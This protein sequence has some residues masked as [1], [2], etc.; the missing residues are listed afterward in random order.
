L[1]GL[2]RVI[3]SE[4]PDLGARIIDIAPALAP[5]EAAELAVDELLFGDDEDEVIL[6]GSQRRVPR[7]TPA[8]APAGTAARCKL[9]I[10]QPGRLDNLIW[11]ELPGFEPDDDEVE[12]R[13]MATGLNFRDIMFS[14]GLLPE[15]AL[16]NGFAGASLGLEMAGVVTKTGKKA[17][18]FKPGDRVAGFAPACFASH[19]LAP[20]RALAPIPDNLDFA[21]A[22]SSPTIFV[23]AWHALK[24]L[25]QV[26]PGETV[27]IHGGAGG[28]GLAAIQICKRLGA[29][30]LATAGSPEKRD[31]LR[32][33]GADGVFDSRSLDF[34]DEITELFG[35]VDVVLNSLAGEAMRRSAALLKPF[36]RFLEL[37]KRDYVE[38]TSL[39]LR[40]FKENISYFSIDVD[41]LLT[42]KPA[43]AIELYE[44]A[45][46]LLRDGEFIPPP[47]RVF[48]ASKVKEAFRAMRQAR[49]VGKIVVDM[50]K[51][52]SMPA[53]EGKPDFSGAWIVGGGT[54][55]FG[56]A[57][58]KHLARGGATKV[59]LASRRGP[60]VPDAGRIREEFEALG[61][62]VRLEACDFS[63]AD[64]VRELTEKYRDEPLTGVV[65]AAAVFNDKYLNDMTEEDFAVALRPKLAGAINLHE[66][67]K[68]LP[69]RYFVV[70]S[71]VSVALG[72][73]G[74][75]NYVAAN[76]GLEALVLQRRKMGLPATAIAWGPVAD[77]GY[78]ARNPLVGKSL[79]SL[80]GR[81][82][83]AAETALRRF[84]D[85]AARG[86]VA[87]AANADWKT[88]SRLFPVEPDRLKL[89]A[90][91]GDDGAGGASGISP[92][93]ELLSLPPEEAEEKICRRIIEEA[94]RVLEIDAALIDE[95]R[96]LQ[97]LGLD[98]LMAMELA[99]SLEQKTGLHL[100]P[101]LLQDG[102]AARQLARRLAGKLRGEEEDNPEA[103][104]LELARRHSED[105]APAEAREIIAEMEAGKR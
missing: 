17:T 30:V 19:V 55:G 45:L 11:T 5:A 44:E 22:A 72:N 76:A 98:S 49:H 61:A 36:G 38:N 77:A 8:A 67:T 21:A 20:E 80:L 27:L 69:I 29:R 87:V 84:D 2:A 39:G 90:R 9:D 46:G 15:D 54:S 24:K 14:M 86:G 51:L 93:E 78:L 102:P 63:S 23:T 89:A 88:A 1:T 68:N 26:A 70:F 40:P 53:P 66:A 6:T 31:L 103:S 12:V 50:S 28:V 4:Y 85:L 32:R 73:P 71:S 3:Q 43:L 64:A 91:L 100:P 96:S 97:T 35:G 34:A 42:A 59:I 81:E 65:H 104:L 56:L 13:V 99:L 92:R 79:A 74:Q 18:R 101:M 41:Q 94:A 60:D 95:G 48:P 25:A 105:M 33:L 75:G 52:P 10:P 16:E 58:A 37:G 7:L 62:E 83:F 82:P 47:R 57:C